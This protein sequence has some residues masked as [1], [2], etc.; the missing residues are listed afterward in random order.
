MCWWG[1]PNPIYLCSQPK[2]WQR[3]CTATIS[4]SQSSFARVAVAIGYRCMADWET[5]RAVAFWDNSIRGSMMSP[6]LPHSYLAVH[7]HLDSHSLSKY[8]TVN[9]LKKIYCSMRLEMNFTNIWSRDFM[10]NYFFLIMIQ[11]LWFSQKKSKNSTSLKHPENNY[12]KKERNL[13]IR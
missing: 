1:C 9:D 5:D 13:P 2:I 6:R 7:P 4:Q 11:L 3:N 12:Q 8:W 10:Q